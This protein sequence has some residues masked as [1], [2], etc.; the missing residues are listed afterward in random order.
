MRDYLGEARQMLRSLRVAIITE[1][2]ICDAISSQKCRTWAEK[3]ITPLVSTGSKKGDLGRLHL[4]PHSCLGG[5]HSF[6]RA[7]N[8]TASWATGSFNRVKRSM[9][10]T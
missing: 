1:S 8:E 7:V 3:K 5:E 10:Q 2:V 6:P 4:P 9:V